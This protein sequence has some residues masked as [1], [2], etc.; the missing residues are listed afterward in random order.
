MKKS[1]YT[2]LAVLSLFTLTACVEM[3]RAVYPKV[4]VTPQNQVQRVETDS[5]PLDTYEL[6]EENPSFGGGIE[7]AKEVVQPS[8]TLEYVDERLA[9]YGKKLDRWKELD[10]MTIGLELSQNETQ[11]M[12]RCFRGIQQVLNGYTSLRTALL[13]EDGL[14]AVT[15]GMPY[16]VQKEDVAFLDGECGILLADMLD[17]Q[18]TLGPG[19]EL[20]GLGTIESL[21]AEYSKHRE[22]ENVLQKWSEVPADQ[23]SRLSLE[24]K[25]LY[26]QALIYLHQE[27]QAI[28]LYEE[29]IQSMRSSVGTDLLSLYKKVADL[30]TASGDYQAATKQYKV[31]EDEYR[32]M[33]KLSDWAALQLSILA[34]SGSNAAE[35]TAYSRLLRDYLGFLPGRDG[36]KVVWQAENFL[37]DY[38]YSPVASNADTIKKDVMLV[39]DTWYKGLW[40][41]VDELSGDNKFEDA[42]AFLQTIPLELIGPEKEAAVN[43]RIDELLLADAVS[44]E[45]EKM[46][47]IQELQKQWN[48]A[49]LLVRADKFDE[50]IQ[51]FTELLGTE[52]DDKATAK[53]AEISL[54]AAQEDRR[55][56][57]DAFI[58]YT[59]TTD[60][61]SQKLLLIESR[62]IL[63]QI[64]IDYPDV[65]I[66]DKVRRN[67]GRVE[68]EMNKIDPQLLPMVRVREMNGETETQRPDFDAFDQPAEMGNQLPVEQM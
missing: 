26:G 11:R 35:L 17:G 59:K 55:R 32:A 1:I 38:P 54:K 19:S 41:T 61:E 8:L 56:A 63:R 10:E 53:I 22:Y 60:V 34:R 5:K 44:R 57:A 33:A 21:I 47:K 39:A 13:S 65:E 27:D 6:Y 50:A 23:R 24:T 64:L 4:P 29:I 2:S 42:V 31:I 46:E 25:V 7:E 45:T 15:P 20:K 48:E 49:M 52:Y 62:K 36:Y 43:A 37:K 28:K 58:R 3:K 66:A 9:A 51:G 40:V 14:A 30:H 12:V 18:S 67:I 68:Q 16:K